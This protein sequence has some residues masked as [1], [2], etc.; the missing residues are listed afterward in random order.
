MAGDI[1]SKYST[2]VA[3]TFTSVNSLAGS[4]TFLAG[5]G[6][7]AQENSTSLHLD[8]LLS[9]KITWSS[10]AP[11]AGTYRMDFHA[12]GSLNDTPDY[13]LDGSGNALGTDLARTFASEG[14]KFNSTHFVGSLTLAATASKVYTL[15]PRGIA[16]L[17]GGPIPKYFGIWATHAVTTASS[18]PAASG[19][20]VW[21]TPVLAQYT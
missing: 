1:K 20:T 11:A 6:S 17:F 15:N 19:N 5:A 4:S 2:V 8:W 9:A 14:D 18:T 10:T 21:A 3:L 13:P 7:L 16:S 12:Y